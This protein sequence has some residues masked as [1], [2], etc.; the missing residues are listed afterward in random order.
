MWQIEEYLWISSNILKQLLR[1]SEMNFQVL[2]NPLFSALF[3]FLKPSAM[4]DTADHGALLNGRQT[5][6]RL[7]S[8]NSL[9]WSFPGFPV[10]WE[11]PCTFYDSEPRGTPSPPPRSDLTTKAASLSPS[12]H[13][14]S[15]PDYTQHILILSFS[16]TSHVRLW[17][18]QGDY[19]PL[20]CW[21]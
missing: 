5:P 3:I 18:S 7:T 4:F 10:W 9:F 2:A 15:H 1:G 19:S 14:P 12:L 6:K 17:V 16:H 21:P 20:W 13:S 8:S 11:R